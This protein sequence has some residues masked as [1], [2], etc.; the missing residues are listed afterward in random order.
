[1]RTTS[2][3]TRAGGQVVLQSEATG[4]GF[5]EFARIR[6]EVVFHGPPPATVRLDGQP[7]ATG[8]RVRVDDTGTGFR[9][10]LEV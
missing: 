5:P 7:I 4:D 9:L 1:V 10:E 8:T 2:T 6:F 3:V